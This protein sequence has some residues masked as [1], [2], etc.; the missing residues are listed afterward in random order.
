M[1][2][3]PF[4]HEITFMAQPLPEPA[5]CEPRARISGVKMSFM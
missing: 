4:S 3:S 1:M 2:V 5:L